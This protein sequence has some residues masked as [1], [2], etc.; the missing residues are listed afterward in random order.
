MGDGG[1]VPQS[2]AAYFG[3]G[4]M[5]QL[6]PD[7]DNIDPYAPV[8]DLPRNPGMLSPEYSPT[9]S[10]NAG[11]Q[12]GG[13]FPPLPLPTLP[14]MLPMPAELGPP[15]VPPNVPRPPTTTTAA[16]GAQRASLDS[17][18]EEGEVEDME[19]YY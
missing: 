15:P 16:E 5:Q 13:Y 11:G 14:P 18:L 8:K 6:S 17:Q 2:D 19:I 7:L 10:P 4:L 12:P 1:G 3:Q 9:L